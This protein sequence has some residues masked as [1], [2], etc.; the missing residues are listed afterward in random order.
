MS[1]P[2]IEI[3]IK[4]I[5]DFRETIND[6]V[7]FIL[8]NE[9]YCKK[10]NIICACM[11]RVNDIVEYLN[12]KTLGDQRG[13]GCAFDL[14]E[15][16][17]H[18]ALMLD[19]INTMIKTLDAQSRIYKPD[20]V[21]FKS[22]KIVDLKL[23]DNSLKTRAGKREEPYLH[24]DDLYFEYIRSIGAI[25]SDNT[26][27]HPY[28]QQYR[29]GE[30]SPFLVW[31]N[32]IALTGGG[33]ICL[34][35][36]DSSGENEGIQRLSLYLDEIYKYIIDRYMRVETLNDVIC[37]WVNELKADL[38][39]KRIK[40]KRDFADYQDYLIYLKNEAHDRCDEYAEDSID[41][42]IKTTNIMGLPEEIEVKYCKY[43]NAL[44]Y[45]TDDLRRILQSMPS[46]DEDN[47]EKMLA[48][49][50]ILPRILPSDQTQMTNYEYEKTYCLYD[51]FMYDKISLDFF[52]HRALQ[53]YSKVRDYA[54]VDNGILNS[55]DNMQI[56][57]ILNTALYFYSID[58]DTFINKKIPKTRKY[59]LV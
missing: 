21:Y 2:L 37:S 33:D 9:V 34:Q 39:N 47:I 41:H 28:F 13:Y 45:A 16:L 53:L 38:R 36:Y 44:M 35:V 24:E 51:E 12:S 54:P 22:K 18:A 15:F 27:R 25:H 6:N 55:L 48:K 5:E 10:W 52:R 42:I 4:P 14:V 43:C 58:H 26:D 7:D 17:S 8:N 30:V 59:R 46:S 31:N 19:C 57:A 3:P 29:S 23:L 50:L 40:S 20:K 11:V 56:L 49:E 1:Y 32:M